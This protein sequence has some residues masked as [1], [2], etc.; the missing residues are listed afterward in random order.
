MDPPDLFH[1]GAAPA[2]FPENLCLRREE[3]TAAPQAI[4]LLCPAD[5]I[6]VR[7]APAD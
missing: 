4:F 3:P 6:D 7:T 5:E 2:L 1:A